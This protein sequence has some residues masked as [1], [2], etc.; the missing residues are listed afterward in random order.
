MEK[1][2]EQNVALEAEASSS[3]RNLK[4]DLCE[5]RDVRMLRGRRDVKALNIPR[6]R[7]VKLNELPKQFFMLLPLLLHWL[8][9]SFLGGGK[10]IHSAV[11]SAYHPSA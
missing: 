6:Q 9:L 3:F 10:L 1:L 7:D 4:A 11:P 8:S 2:V 5:A